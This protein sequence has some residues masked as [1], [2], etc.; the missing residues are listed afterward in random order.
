LDISPKEAEDT[1]AAI[2]TIGQKA[3]R[4]I[5]SGAFNVI[6]IITGIVWLI[7]FT[8]TQFL[9]QEF[10]GY[11]WTGLSVLGSILGTILGIQNN[12]RVRSPSIAPIAKRVITFWLLLV[13]YGISF[14]AIAKPT[15]GKQA[16]LMIILFIMLGWLTT[17]LLFSFFLFWWVLPITALALIGYFLLPSFFYL[18][19]AVLGGGSMIIFGIYIRLRW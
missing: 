5:A 6:L 4:S 16:T 18:W 14:I 12:K 11:I 19:M 8:C 10:I 17:G 13:C 15:D 9:P 2:Q 1:L 7:G 3:R